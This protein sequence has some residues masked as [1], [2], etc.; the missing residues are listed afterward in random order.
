M[1]SLL[2]LMIERDEEEGGLQKLRRWR[3]RVEREFRVDELEV[4]GGWQAAWR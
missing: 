3:G 2:L 1:P 4:E